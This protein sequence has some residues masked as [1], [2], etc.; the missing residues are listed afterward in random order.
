MFGQNHIVTPKNFTN[1]PRNHLVVR[2]IFYTLQG[3]GMFA[4]CPAIFVRLAYCNLKCEFCDTYFDA[5]EA[6][7]FEQVFA[8]MEVLLNQHA[9]TAIGDP[10]VVITGGEPTMQPHLTGFLEALHDAGWVSQIESNGNFPVSLPE[11]CTLVIS[12]KIN[13]RTGKYIKLN[14]ETLVEAAALKFIISADRALYST[15]PRFALDWWQA[16]P[17]TRMVFLSPMNEYA[18][19]PK[20]GEEISVWNAGLLDAARNEPNHKL[21]AK[22]CMQYGVRLS[23]Q[24]HVYVGLP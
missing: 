21:A 9:N 19:Q 15:V 4:G 22:L 10:L 2:S 20:L 18:R 12:P 17:N 13:E 11:S 23:L 8:R 16:A 6:L 24:Q 5:G 1:V 7:D 14:A 3:E